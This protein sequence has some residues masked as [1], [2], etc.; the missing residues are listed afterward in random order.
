MSKHNPTRTA[1]ACLNSHLK[2]AANNLSDGFE[3]EVEAK[4]RWK[5]ILSAFERVG[6]TSSPY[7][8]YSRCTRHSPCNTGGCPKCDRLNRLAD[9]ENL[10]KRLRGKTGGRALMIAVS[11]IPKGSQLTGKELK[12]YDWP[13]A[14]DRFRKA[15]GRHMSGYRTFCRLSA[16]ISYNDGFYS[17]HLHGILMVWGKSGSD[18]P[19]LRKRLRKHLRCA[20][21]RE[22]E[23]AHNPVRLELIHDLPNWITYTTKSLFNLHRIQKGTSLGK[24]EV[25]IRI[26]LSRMT[27]R[28]RSLEMR[29]KGGEMGSL[30]E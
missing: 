16:D 22:K 6:H 7:P 8:E 29:T 28:R 9:A 10:T 2:F 26:F 21:N 27:R 25:P 13:K 20:F 3:T 11:I 24:R 4:H 5:D 19:K 15:Y 30:S 1:I 23:N 12:N 18:W 17:L 14:C